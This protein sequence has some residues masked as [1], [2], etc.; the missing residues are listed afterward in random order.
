MGRDNEPFGRAWE[1]AELNPNLH[2]PV[3][4]KLMQLKCNDLS[5]SEIIESRLQL[6]MRMEI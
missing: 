1:L 2:G 6:S 5:V 4:I 3:K